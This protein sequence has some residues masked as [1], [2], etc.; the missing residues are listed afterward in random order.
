MPVKLR[1]CPISWR[2]A[3]AALLAAASLGNPWDLTARD[4]RWTA[5][6]SAHFE[7]FT[8]GDEAGGRELVQYFE[9]VRSFFQ[10]AFGLNGRGRVVR[11]VYFRSARQLQYYDTNKL[12]DAA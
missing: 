8:E 4:D 6:R 7:L 11:I 9:Q 5:I 10:Q 1:A 3:L 12:A 2:R